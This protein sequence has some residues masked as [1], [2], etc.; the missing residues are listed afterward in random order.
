MSYLNVPRLYFAGE[1]IADPNT[2]N[3]SPP[4]FELGAQLPPAVQGWNPKGTGA[5]SFSGCTV[6]AVTYVDGEHVVAP[7]DDPALGASVHS[8]ANPSGG[9]M[10]D[11]DPDQQMVSE[12]WGLTVSLGDTAGSDSFTGDYTPAAFQDIWPAG[13]GGQ[14][15]FR[16]WYQSTITGVQWAGSLGSRLLSEL[17][18]ASD[19]VLSIK[20]MLDR[21]NAHNPALANGPP[22]FPDPGNGL[23]FTHGRI[24]GAI[25]PGTPGEP[26]QL[27]PARLLRPMPGS[28]PMHF[29]PCVVDTARRKVVV[30]LGNSIKA[31]HLRDETMEDLGLLELAV[32]PADGDPVLLGPLDY[33]AEDWYPTTAGIAEFPPAGTLSDHQLALLESNPLGIVAVPK[34]KLGHPLLQENPDGSFLKADNFV[35]RLDPGVA[36]RQVDLYATRFGAPLTGATITLGVSPN[37]PNSPNALP[38]PVPPPTDAAGKTSFTWQPGNPGNPRPDDLDGE[39]CFITYEL[40][41]FVNTY[42]DDN[43][44]LSVHLYAEQ[45]AVEQPTWWG[46]VRPILTQYHQ[47]YPVMAFIPLDD[48]RAVVKSAKQIREAI[49][50]PLTAPMYMPVTRDLSASR[51]ALLN[52]WF[53]NGTPEGEPPLSA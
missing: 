43:D 15:G 32:L 24:V 1:F 45:P 51:L 37:S 21:Y 40:A 27:V 35:Y 49:N 4:N 50:R 16:V 36:D 18:Q 31:A 20:F 19:G 46:E 52:R 25:G 38:L 11:L 39:V 5:W 9:K 34:S 42:P 44:F 12:L 33:Q 14:A 8:V 13:P 17:Q 3:N 48:Y 53:D 7:G 41:D 2:I 29:A 6:T 28:S 23:A 10:V 30:D 47:L 22:N 26:R